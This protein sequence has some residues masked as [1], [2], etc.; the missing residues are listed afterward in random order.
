AN[1]NGGNLVLGPDGFLY[2]GL[3]DGG[4]GDD[5]DH[6][7]QDPRVLLGTMLRVDVIVADA[8]PT[9]YQIPSTNPLTVTPAG[10]RPALCAVRQRAASDLSR[11]VF[12][13]RLR[14]GAGLVDR[15]GRRRGR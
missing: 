10:V 4:S 15:A 3:G 1:Q 14:A 6:R 2:I 5:P 9:G 11:T 7:A 13:R 12:L 8:D